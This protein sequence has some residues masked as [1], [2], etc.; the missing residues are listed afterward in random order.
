MILLGWRCVN[1][2][3]LRISNRIHSPRNFAARTCP[4]CC[5]FSLDLAAHFVACFAQAVE[6][7]GIDFP[8]ASDKQAL[9]VAHIPSRFAAG[10]DAANVFDHRCLATGRQA[11]D[12]RQSGN[13]RT[14]L[15]LMRDNGR[16]VK[17]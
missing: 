7:A 9:C 14:R 8:N 15:W 6:Y 1:D 10:H 3:L 17:S 16:D 4:I 13:G 5:T 2:E 12:V 11:F